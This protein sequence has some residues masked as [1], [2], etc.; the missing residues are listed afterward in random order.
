M[1]RACRF[2]PQAIAST[3]ALLAGQALAAGPAPGHYAAVLPCADCPGIEVQLDI[4]ADGSYALRERYRDREEAGRDHIGRWIMASDER[5]LVLRGGHEQ[6][7][8]F[9]VE[10]DRTLV[11]LDREAQPIVSSLDYHLRRDD[12]LPPLVPR[13]TLTGLFHRG[14]G[15]ATFQECGIGQPL[16]VAGAEGYAALEQAYARAKGPEDVALMTQLR[17]RI[18]PRPAANG[19]AAVP[20]LVVE[21]FDSFRPGVSCLPPLANAPLA[22]THW[23]LTRL[24]DTPVQE[25]LTQ[26]PH[27]VFD[28]TGRVIGATGCN[29]LVARY[30]TEGRSLR[31]E[32]GFTTRMACAQGMEVE[33]S[34]MAA[35]A[36]ARSWRVAGG[37]LDLYDEGDRLAGRFMAVA[38][39]RN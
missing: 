10:D 9:A 37:M 39:E 23:K 15:P 14:K 1:S 22:G 26:E 18:E 25:G 17:G 29:R 13:L 7:L 24:G 8:Y 38:E 36:A 4:A 21:A 28:P 3:L 2:L 12:A 32:S 16:P 34:M 19:G 20:T 31:I 35:L 30:I 27:V 5:T 11:Q 6:P 33:K